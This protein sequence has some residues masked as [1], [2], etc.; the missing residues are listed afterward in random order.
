MEEKDNKF[1]IILIIVI[2]MV[3]AIVGVLYWGLNDSKTENL[4]TEM[5]IE[6]DSMLTGSKYVSEEIKGYRINTSEK[7][8]ET[9][10]FEGLE[11]KITQLS[12][13]DNRTTFLGTIK[14]TTNNKFEG[15]NILLTIYDDKGNELAKENIG[16]VIQPIDANQ[17]VELNIS[18]I[19]D[20]A[21]AYDFK[22]ERATE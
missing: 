19:N 15:S 14:N 5:Q 7:V 21:N 22:L 11:I 18:I 20:Y 16:N 8:K 1:I 3:M 13:I 6:E 2:I 17:E 9:K 12:S 4:P 10:Y